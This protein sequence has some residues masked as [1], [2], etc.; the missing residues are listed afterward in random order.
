MYTYVI[1]TK[2]FTVVFPCTHTM[3]FDQ[4]HPLLF[5]LIILLFLVFNGFH[6]CIFT[7]VYH[8]LFSYSPSSLALPAGSPPKQTSPFHTRVN[9]FQ[10]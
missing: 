9:R 1:H 10:V 4:I 7:H 5:F 2:G 3:P 8:D 6:Y